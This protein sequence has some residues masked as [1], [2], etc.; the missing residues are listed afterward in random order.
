MLERIRAR[1]IKET[2][3]DVRIEGARLSDV[4][5][6]NDLFEQFFAESGYGD[7][8]IVYSR[9]R[10]GEWLARVIEFGL[11]P[12]IVARLNDKI[13][14][15]ISY[16]LDHSFCKDPIAVLHTIYVVPLHRRTAIGRMLVGL[17]TITAKTTDGAC[18]FHAPVASGMDETTSLQNLFARGGF[19]PIGFIMGRA[20]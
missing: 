18:A 16:D 10:A 15:V 20:L 12:H 7:R 3:L 2:L 5:E 1:A 4:G 11:T 9:A 8:G 13:I 17:A 14:G 6:L 19:E